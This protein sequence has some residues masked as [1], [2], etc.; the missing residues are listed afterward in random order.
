MKMLFGI[1]VGLMLLFSN[2]MVPAASSPHTFPMTIQIKNKAP[3]SL[4]ALQATAIPLYQLPTVNAGGAQSFTTIMPSGTSYV[5]YGYDPGHFCK[6]KFVVSRTGLLTHTS[7][8]MKQKVKNCKINISG[9]KGALNNASVVIESNVQATATTH[10]VIT[11]IQTSLKTYKLHINNKTNI[12]TD[13]TSS[14]APSLKVH[15][16]NFVKAFLASQILILPDIA[17]KASQN[18][19]VKLAPG[20]QLK[21]SYGI[22]NNHQCKF[23]IRIDSNYAIHASLGNSS[24]SMTCNHNGSSSKKITLTVGGPTSWVPSQ[25]CVTTWGFNGY[26]DSVL[27]TPAPD[28]NFSL[29]GQTI[30]SACWKYGKKISLTVQHISSN[31]PSNN[32]SIQFRTNS[33]NHNQILQEGLKGTVQVISGSGFTVNPWYQCH[34]SNDNYKRSNP[35]QSYQ[36]AKW[37]LCEDTLTYIGT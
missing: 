30:Q 12:Q 19:Q 22:N 9:N 3:M 8:S 26:A 20:D 21:I 29:P 34:R 32:F 17:A 24:E 10:A 16:Y 35:I 31:T 37:K 25:L 23:I 5:T 27:V 6:L 15:S 2:T 11:G 1:I 33:L 14:F 13:S 28:G 36:T 7:V 18:I 4:Q